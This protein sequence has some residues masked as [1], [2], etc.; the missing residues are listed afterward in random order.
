MAL[1]ENYLTDEALADELKNTP[2]TLALWRQRGIGP[3]WTKCG[4]KVLYERVAVL[5]WLKSQQ[6]QPVRNR[7]H[8]NAA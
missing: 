1:L 5:A 7:R 3:P 8:S 4:A 2:R 6:T